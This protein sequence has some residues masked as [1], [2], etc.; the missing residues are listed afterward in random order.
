MNATDVGGGANFFGGGGGGGGGGV[1]C[2]GWGPGSHSWDNVKFNPYPCRTQGTTDQNLGISWTFWD[3][4]QYKLWQCDLQ[5]IVY[6][7]TTFT[8]PTCI[9]YPTVLK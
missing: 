2:R 1:G 9:A 5:V 8:S 6:Y 3:W 7:H 4:W